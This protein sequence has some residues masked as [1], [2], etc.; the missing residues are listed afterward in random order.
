RKGLE[1][2]VEG[3]LTY[4]TYEDGEGQTRYITEVV[5]NEMLML[6]KRPAHA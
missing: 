3:R 6:D 5:A 4:R 2:A 1:I